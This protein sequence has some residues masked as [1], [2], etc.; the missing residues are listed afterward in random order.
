MNHPRW[1]K[2][3]RVYLIL[4][5]LT[6][7][8]G[9]LD[10]DQHFDLCTIES[11]EGVTTRI[12]YSDLD[13]ELMPKDLSVGFYR[14]KSWGVSPCPFLIVYNCSYQTHNMAGWAGTMGDFWFFGFNAR[15]PLVKKWVS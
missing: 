15:F 12:P 1:K 2:A 8:W 3:I 10:A 4:W 5:G 6:W 13:A 14:S 11:Q 7:I 9:S